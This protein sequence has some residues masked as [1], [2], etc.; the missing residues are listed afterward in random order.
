M[1]HFYD[2]GRRTAL[3][4]FGRFLGRIVPGTRKAVYE[5]AQTAERALPVANKAKKLSPEAKKRL[6]ETLAKKKHLTR[7][8]GPW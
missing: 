1:N 6:N 2:L 7:V 8:T 3:E 5:V 4:K